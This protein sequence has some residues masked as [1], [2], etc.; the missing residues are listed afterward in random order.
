ML[1]LWPRESYLDYFPMV[2]N[3]SNSCNIYVVVVSKT[4]SMYTNM[5]ITPTTKFKND[6]TVYEKH[7]E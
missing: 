2:A 3:F 7:F 6:D 5:L 1:M 4:K